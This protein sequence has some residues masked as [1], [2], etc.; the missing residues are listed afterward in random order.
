ML[1][2]IEIVWTLIGN[3]AL[4]IFI[5]FVT[6]TTKKRV[7]QLDEFY[8]QIKKIEI[9]L[10]KINGAVTENT[11]YRTEHKNVHMRLDSDIM[12]LLK[13]CFTMHGVHPGDK[14]G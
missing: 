2:P 3:A 4:N 6:I 9:H 11:K 13:R 10:A 5:I 8:E 1:I 12:D 7:R 14:E